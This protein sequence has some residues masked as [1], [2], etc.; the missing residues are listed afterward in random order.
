VKRGNAQRFLEITATFSSQ[1]ARF[2]ISS[3]MIDIGPKAMQQDD[4][5]CI[6]YGAA[7]P[8]TIRPERDGTGCIL[9]GECYV[10]DLM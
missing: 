8:F 7:V 2:T 6:L 3:G 10:Y 9:I 5:L 4:M 1:R